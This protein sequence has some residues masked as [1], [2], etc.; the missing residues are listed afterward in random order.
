MPMVNFTCPLYYDRNKSVMRD[1]D[2]WKIDVFHILWAMFKIY[3]FLLSAS[4]R[5]FITSQINIEGKI[6]L[7]RGENP[8]R[9]KLL[10]LTFLILIMK[11]FLDLPGSVH[12]WQLRH[13][14]RTHRMTTAPQ[15]WA[16][17]ALMRK[18][19]FI[20]SIIPQIRPQMAFLRTGIVSVVVLKSKSF[21]A[22]VIIIH[23]FQES[24]QEIKSERKENGPSVARKSTI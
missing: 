10:F 2:L 7:G 16:W 5:S 6:E 3:L 19:L 11:I 1:L 21:P 18:R 24:T 22:G 13:W 17:I 4:R 20:A 23:C 9:P 12:Y 8:N 15:N 14:P